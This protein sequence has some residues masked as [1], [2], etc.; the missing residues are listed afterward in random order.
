MMRIMPFP[1]RS[2]TTT[3]DVLREQRYRRYV[4]RGDNT[5]AI[6][7]IST[8]ALALLVTIRNDLLL[9]RGTPLL[10][11]VV[12]A[13]LVLFVATAVSA[14]LLWR[15]TWPRQADRVLGIWAVGLSLVWTLT[16]AS[17]IPSGESQ[18]PLFSSVVLLCILYFA[19]R[20]PIWIRAG[21]AAVV[22]AVAMLILWNP[23]ADLTAIGRA[24]GTV[25]MIALNVIGI[26]AA[27]STEEQRR[28]RFEAERLERHARRELT[29]K[30]R[31]LAIEKERAEAMS[32]AR[33]TFLATMSHEFRTPMNAV[34]GFSTLLLDT[35]L[36][37]RQCEY[38]TT[39]Q[40][41]AQGLLGLLNDVLD[42]TKID[43]EK[44]TL[45]SAPFELRRL[46]SSVVAM[47]RPAVATRPVDLV[48]NMS[49]D[50]PECV[51]GDEMRVR[52][53]LVNLLSNAIKFTER[54]HVQLDVASRA[55]D[56]GEHEI[57]FRVQ[58][59]GIGMSPEVMSRVFQ[60]FEQGDSG[61]TR[62]Y[63]GTGLGL[64]ISKRILES[65]GG[66]L[67][68]ESD[69]GN[70]SVFS[71]SVRFAQSERPVA[72]VVGPALQTRHAKLSILVVDDHPVNR[73]IA[74]GMLERLGHRVDLAR[75]G[76]E[77]IDAVIRRDYD[78]VFMDL[79]MPEM[80]GIE[81]TQ[82][83]MDELAGKHAP[84]IV[85]MTASVFEEDREACRKAGMRDF[86][87]KPIDSAQLEAILSRISDDHLHSRAS[88]PGDGEL[89]AE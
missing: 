48:V 64:A 34:L 47:M 88:M 41:S 67:R 59:T 55:L 23:N 86:V 71:F 45:A 22:T 42:F 66:V 89:A 21:T 58:D 25:T 7:I 50:V 24:T 40:D 62:S 57:T 1:A 44:L 19:Q 85:A 43:A 74:E 12:L 16:L 73:R 70:G 10:L 65:M 53:V 9:L 20:G 52:Q 30:M 17:R 56:G 39:I 13:K 87:V 4:L 61:T 32:R 80:G 36:D 37:A 77:A 28:K 81:A 31:E 49:S 72:K 83:I 75:N 15:T 8:I 76:L 84:A 3:V 2:T 29:V 11:V 35:Q 27:R 18:G 60:P 54:G 38:V 26:V 82:R 78:A 6:A 63:G 51:L 5:L 69:V 46:T 79:Q 68:A 14:V 33:T